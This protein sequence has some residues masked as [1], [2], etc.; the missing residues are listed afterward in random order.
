MSRPA[1]LKAPS[2]IFLPLGKEKNGN[3]GMDSSKIISLEDFA[4]KE[5]RYPSEEEALQW[6]SRLCDLFQGSEEVFP[7]ISAKAIYIENGESWTIAHPP[8]TPDESEALYRLGVVLHS[9]LTRMPFQ[10]SHYLDGPP[11]VRERNPQISVRLEAIVTKLLQ[12]IRSLR[13]VSLAELKQDL[14]RLQKDLTGDWVIHWPCFKGSGT[15]TN[16]ISEEAFQPEGKT[17]KEVWRAP[18][19]EI[20]ASPVMG[21][22]NLFIGSGN[23]TFYSMDAKTGKVVWQTNLGAR[24]ESTACIHK[25]NAYLGNDLGNFYAIHIKKGSVQ[26][27]KALGEY[28]RCSAFCEGKSIYVGS[29]NPTRKSGVFWNLSADSGSIQWKKN[30]GPIFSSPVVDKEDI[31]IGSDDE[32]LYCLSATGTEKWRAQLQGKVRATAVCVREFLYVGCF[33][34]FFYKIRRSTGEIVWKNQK[35]G[36]MYSSPGYGKQF[37]VAG[38]NAGSVLFFQQGTGR[39]KSEFATGGPVTASPLV[40]NHYALVGSND[41]NFYILDSDGKVVTSFDAKSPINSSALFHEGIIYVG[42]DNGMHALSL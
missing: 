23:G 16:S 5:N 42:S 12:N 9:L 17:L 36:S 26:W 8:T 19:G 29:I 18:I 20:W 4:R 2:V 14:D 30:V 24:I 1:K 28:V 31:L 21:G 37:L 34:G 15:R 41:G 25:N 40:I 13:Y 35:A 22:E 7:L 6:A 10:I 32:S 3:V 39:I 33:G 38:N 11:S 27:K